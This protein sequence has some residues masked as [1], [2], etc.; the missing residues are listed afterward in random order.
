M[1]LPH[2]SALLSSPLSS[3]TMGVENESSGVMLGTQ[4]VLC[5]KVSP[6]KADTI[7]AGTQSGKLCLCTLSASTGLRV[8]TVVHPFSHDKSE[9]DAP[10]QSVGLGAYTPS[11]TALLSSSALLNSSSSSLATKETKRALLA[12]GSTNLA[13][14]VSA[15]TIQ[16]H[17]HE[18]FPVS[19]IC[20]SPHNPQHLIVGSCYGALALLDA[21]SGSLV[22]YFDYKECGDALRGVVWSLDDSSVFYTIT[23]QTNMIDK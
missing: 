8:I 5:V 1:P 21:S 10:T 11:A 6:T 15:T 17:S 4:R 13:S 22:H 18:P 19:V 3:H 7:A 23:G 12:P 9:K 14:S 16:Q 20:F 2:S